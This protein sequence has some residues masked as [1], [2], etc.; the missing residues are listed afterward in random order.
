MHRASFVLFTL[1]AACDTPPPSAPVCLEPLRQEGTVVARVGDVPIT[2]QQLAARLE[3]QGS[4]VVRRHADPQQ[5]RQFVEDQVRF[6]LLVRAALE[7]GLAQDPDVVDAAH[8]VMVRKLLQRDMGSQVFEGAVDE[9]A[10]AAFYEKHK[11][12]YMQPEM[13]RFADIELAPTEEGRAQA[14][15]IIDQLQK[16]PED[17][18]LFRLLVVRHS[19][20]KDAKSRGGESM[21]VSND[22]LVDTHGQSYAQAIFALQPNALAAQPVQSTRGWHVVR[23]VAVRE[24]LARSLDE[25]RE[26]IREK[27]MRGKRSKA[28]E[29]YLSQLKGRY[30]VAIYEDKIGDVIATITAPKPDT[31]AKTP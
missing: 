11:D 6:N 7:R 8:K 19:L 4:A 13:R 10:I 22:E 23:M 21:F 29:Q 12:D 28:F 14:I 2:V 5:M 24:R 26:E 27:L 25:V 18:N 3:E 17:K 9:A 31:Q 1:A 30:P 16:H 15:A 20:D